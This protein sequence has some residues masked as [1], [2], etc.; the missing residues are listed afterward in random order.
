MSNKFIWEKNQ[1]IVKKTDNTKT[2]KPFRKQLVIKIQDNQKD[3]TITAIAS[4]G[5]VDR[6]D[7]TLN[8]RNWVLTGF[9]KNPAFLYAH[10]VDKQA[11]P[12]GIITSLKIVNDQMWI[13]IYFPK[14]EEL[15]SYFDTPELIHDH[16][17][18]VDLIYNAYK[19]KLIKAISVGFNGKWKPRDES[20]PYG[21]RAFSEQ[22]LLEISGVPI[23]C[24]EDA[25]AKIGAI[26][27]T[28]KQYFNGGDY[29]EIKAGARLS[30][31]S[32]T[33]LA[34]IHKEM[35][36]IHKI[37]I[38]GMKGCHKRLSEFIEP[39]CADEGEGNGEGQEDAKSFGSLLDNINLTL[40]KE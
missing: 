37:Y 7:D 31:E 30:K 10:N 13:E 32:K 22:T 26:P 17:K 39:P 21:G 40:N 5:D 8:M 36:E 25:L 20:R 1:I 2:A 12:I 16:A 23:G 6:A 3:R 38:D 24:N 27:E 9:L 35:A 15:T 33:A 29:V 34:A 19:C 4:T 14:I 18:F 11:V 28:L